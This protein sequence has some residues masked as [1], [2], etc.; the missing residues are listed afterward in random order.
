MPSSQPAS[1]DRFRPPRRA[2]TAVALG[3]LLTVGTGFAALNACRAA[4]QR[5]LGPS[6]IPAE[7]VFE[8]VSDTHLPDA[9]RRG[10]SMEA[11]AADFDGD[12]DLDLLIAKEKLPNVLLLNDGAGRFADASDRLPRAWHDSEDIAVADF[13]G[14]G[15]LDAV[16]VSEDDGVPE[17]YL[18]DG[19]ARFTDA[20]DRLPVRAVTNAVAMGDVDGDGDVDLVLGSAGPDH[21]LLND[22]R[23][24]FGEPAEGRLPAFGDVTQDVALGDVDGDRD[25]DLLVG[26]EDGNRL[27]LNDGHG[28]FTDAS[29]RLP[30]P[31]SPEETRNADFGDVD[32]DGDLDVLF[33]NVRHLYATPQCRLLVNDGTGRF[34]DQTEARLPATPW[35]TMDGDF[36]DVDRDGDLDLVTT[37][38]PRGSRPH[39]F[40]NDG[41]GRFAEASAA[42]FP[43]ALTAEGIE[44]EAAD[45]D[46][47]GRVDLYMADYRDLDHLLLARRDPLRAVAVASAPR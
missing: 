1:S 43:H 6:T 2:L 32:G 19:T 24:R 36:V 8:D 42:Y 37:G 34:A 22:G 47:D 35:S 44:L 20:G 28:R 13:D 12:G 46:G 3:V 33:S 16:V 30:A 39:L 11:R 25:L 40:L 10:P 45:F 21:L 4:G 5:R 7:P 31:P 17:Y 9:A 23:G 15:D 26:N 27:L 14:D 29:A 41:H 38:F 18:N